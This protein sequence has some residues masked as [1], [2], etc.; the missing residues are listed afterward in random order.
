MLRTTAASLLAL[1]TAILPVQAQTV[2]Y[3]DQPV[4]PPQQPY[5]IEPQQAVP[6]ATQPLYYESTPAPTLSQPPAVYQPEPEQRIFRTVPT[7]PVAQQPFAPAEAYQPPRPPAQ[8]APL[9]RA[10]VQAAPFPEPV[11]PPVPDV[12]ESEALRE[13]SDE[14]SRIVS[15]GERYR[16]AS[17]GFLEDLRALADRYGDLPVRIEPEAEDEPEMVGPPPPANLAAP[18]PPS[19][20]DEPVETVEAVEPPAE[21]EQPIEEPQVVTAP[22]PEPEP[23]PVA[24]LEPE[25]EPEIVIETVVAEEPQ[26]LPQALPPTTATTVYLRDDFADGEYF[27]NPAW[28]VRQGDFTIDPTFGLRPS[29]PEAVEPAGQRLQGYHEGRSPGLQQRQAASIALGAAV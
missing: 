28:N 24:M 17:P 3:G 26:E 11:A 16:A 10:P 2:L 15:L 8:T 25:P 12:T 27:S 5:Y 9:G 20:P 4:L 1:A 6:L 14:L 19:E 29:A 13:F 22:E 21:P 7:A 18:T 23:E